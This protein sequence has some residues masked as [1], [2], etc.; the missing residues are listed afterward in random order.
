[1]NPKWTIVIYE[2]DGATF[3]P[4][5]EEKTWYGKKVHT[6]SGVSDFG[7]GHKISLNTA[8]R[9]THAEARSIALAFIFSTERAVV[10]K[11]EEGVWI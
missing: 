6:F 9:P 5:V 10:N 3:L 4:T 2:F 7:V 11:T 1:M 8:Y